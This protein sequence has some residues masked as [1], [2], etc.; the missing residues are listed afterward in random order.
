MIRV[1]GSRV[2]SLSIAI[3]VLGAIVA[4]FLVIESPVEQ[5]IRRLDDARER[6]LDEISKAIDRY[7]NTHA[8]LPDSLENLQPDSEAYLQVHDPVTEEPYGYRTNGSMTYELCAVFQQ[9]TLNDLDG[10]E[11]RFWKHKLGSHCFALS[12]E[13]KRER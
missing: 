7:W 12:V 3:T 13:V 5:R 8:L 4:A 10:S 2:V 6:H 11:K 9:E 1:I